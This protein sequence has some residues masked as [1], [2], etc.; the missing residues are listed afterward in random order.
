MRK[1]SNKDFRDRLNKYEIEYNPAAWLQM[2]N[3][4]NTKK[5]NHKR[6]LFLMAIPFLLF[7]FVTFFFLFNHK[8]GKS[9]SLHSN[10]NIST[11]PNSNQSTRPM[12]SDKRNWSKKINAESLTHLNKNNISL[13]SENMKSKEQIKAKS[14]SNQKKEKLEIRNNAINKNT[15]TQFLDKPKSFS[16]ISNNLRGHQTIEKNRIDVNRIEN[17]SSSLNSESKLNRIEEQNQYSSKFSNNGANRSIEL[18]K[19]EIIHKN[20]SIEDASSQSPQDQIKSSMNNDNSNN[21]KL[22]YQKNTSKEDGKISDFNFE[23][24]LSKPRLIE[25]KPLHLRNIILLNEHIKQGNSISIQINKKPQYYYLGM[26]AGY[27]L[28]ND[29]PGYQ[30]GLSCFKDHNKIIGFES[31][32]LYTYGRREVKLGFYNKERQYDINFLFHVNLMRLL[33]H[34]VSIELGVGYTK[35]DAQLVYYINQELAYDYKSIFGLSYHAGLSYTYYINKGNLV[36]LKAGLISFDDAAA[37]FT[38]KFAKKI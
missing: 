22:S 34:K 30:I 1:M 28:V 31:E 16:R 19:N 5:K 35:Y 17:T 38:I 27:A 6:W 8:I 21:E 18:N 23:E 32:I 15:S 13:S 29:S 14:A 20:V 37:S 25:I 12:T 26:R 33:S 24:I 11:N 4:L 36:S 9:T 7:S 10:K 3:L 2:E